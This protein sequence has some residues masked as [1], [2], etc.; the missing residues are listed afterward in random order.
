MS[1]EEPHRP[2]AADAILQGLRESGVT[3]LFGNFGSDHP[4]IIESLARNQLAGRNLPQVIVCP[5]ESVALSAAHGH[6]LLSHQAQAVVVHCDVGT[7]T[8]GGAMHNASRARIPVFI[9]AGETPFT[10]EGELFGGRNRAVQTLQDVHDQHSIVR[11]YVKWSAS[12]KTGQNARQMVLRAMQIAS[13]APTGPVY[14]TG[15]REYLSE[16]INHQRNTSAARFPSI[17]ASAIAPTL[18]KE[19]ANTLEQATNPLIVVSNGG[20]DPK[21]VTELAKLV[22]RLGIRVVEASRSCVNLDTQHPLHNGYDVEHALADADAVLVLEADTPWDV[23]RIEL[24]DEVPIYHID[25]DPLK[26]NFVLTHTPSSRALAADC[27]TALEQINA[28]AESI[29]VDEQR[30]QHRRQLASAEHDTQQLALAEQELAPLDGSISVPYLL[31]TLSEIITD[32][33]IVVDESITNN[34]AVWRHLPRA[35]PGTYFASGGSSLGWHG[36]A[37]IGMKL[38]KPEAQI[39][40][41]CGDGTYLFSVPSSVHWIAKQYNTPFLT[42]VLNNGG[43]NATKQNTLRLHPHGAASQSDQFFVN[44]DQNTEFAEMAKAAG[45]GYAAKVSAASELAAVLKAGLA[46]VQAGT[47]AVVNVKLAAISQQIY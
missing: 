46:A 38:A 12:L 33:T 24:G 26:Q 34:E 7:Q 16:T 39:V 35:K 14:L 29:S 6:T 31:A 3:H 23:R 19:I 30:H 9:F 15:A 4:E 43:W 28:A 27:A 17:E 42:I 47:A 18:A 40:A 8:L 45:A 25:T 32:D 2:T 22:E 41:L 36:G 20:R 10:I 44:L 37:C 21:A 1:T 11:S 13:S 5:H